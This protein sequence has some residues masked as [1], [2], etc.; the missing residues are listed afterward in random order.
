MYSGSYDGTIR[1]FDID[2]EAFVLGFQAPEDLNEVSFTDIDFTNNHECAY[3]ARKDGKIAFIDMREG[4]K[5]SYSWCYQVHNFKV[6]S[7]QLHPTNNNIL[8]SASSTKDGYICIHDIRT[9]NKNWKCINQLDEHNKS[10]N[11]AYA[12]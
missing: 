1:F 2:K 8:I 10:I 6:N 9:A 7:V 12:R 11:A 3:I 4:N 5:N